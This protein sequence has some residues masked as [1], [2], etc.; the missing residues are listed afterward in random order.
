MDLWEV[1]KA[2]KLGYCGDL[3]EMLLGRALK[4]SKEKKKADKSENE[5]NGKV[6]KTEQEK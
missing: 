2:S 4:Q 1:Y 3:Y 5:P 6:E